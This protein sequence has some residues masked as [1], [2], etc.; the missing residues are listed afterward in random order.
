MSQRAISIALTAA[1]GLERAHPAD[2]QHHPLDVGRVF[3]EQIVLVEE[4]H[5]LEVRL[6]GLGLA[7]P[8]DALIRDDADDRVPADDGAPEVRDL[9][10]S[11]PRALA[12][13]S[14]AFC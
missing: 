1:P 7:V 4:H 12:E 2:L 9:D 14:S 10:R 3:A 8:G 13:A 11:A 6:G 5:R